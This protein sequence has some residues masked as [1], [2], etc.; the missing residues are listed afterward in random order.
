MHIYLRPRGGS[1]TM[2]KKKKIQSKELRDVYRRYG[3]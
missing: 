1:W 3:R 2:Q